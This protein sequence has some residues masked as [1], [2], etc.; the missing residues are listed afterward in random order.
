MGNP[1]MFDDLLEHGADI[2]EIDQNFTGYEFPVTM[3]S[4]INNHRFVTKLCKL[5]IDTSICFRI[6]CNKYRLIYL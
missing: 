4:T 6:F 3:A 2:H 5:G 1:P